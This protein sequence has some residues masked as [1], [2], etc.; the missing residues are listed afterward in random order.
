MFPLPN[1]LRKRCKAQLAYKFKG[2][3]NDKHI[4]MTTK[5]K[6]TKKKDIYPGAWDAILFLEHQRGAKAPGHHHPHRKFGT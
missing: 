3:S 4:S 6:G 2:E 1:A 5:R